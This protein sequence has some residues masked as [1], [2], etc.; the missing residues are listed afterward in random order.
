MM[1]TIY[2]V[3]AVGKGQ[4]GPRAERSKRV[5]NFRV[6]LQLCPRFRRHQSTDYQ[7]FGDRDGAG[8]GGPGGLWTFDADGAF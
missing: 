3:L 6:R 7:L 5:K 1:W 4:K 2:T 8:A